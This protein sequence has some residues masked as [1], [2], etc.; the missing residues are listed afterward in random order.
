VILLWGLRHEAPMAY[1]LRAL[2]RCGA[3]T[4]MIDQRAYPTVTGSLAACQDGAA[5]WISVAGYRRPVEG[6]CG[7]F[8]RPYPVPPRYHHG[9]TL[10]QVA[11]IDQMMLTLA[12]TAPAHIAVVNRP[13][14]MAS[15]DSKPAQLAQLEDLGFLVPDTIV[16][17]D[18]EIAEDFWARHGTVVY[19]STSGIRSIASTLT[20]AHRD[21]LDRLAT[22]P[23]QFQEFIP[24]DDYRVHVVGDET[25][26]THIV[27]TATDYRYAAT[28]AAQRTMAAA[29]LPD[30]VA[31]QCR[32]ATRELGLLLAGIDLRRTPDGDWYCFEVNTAPAFSWFQDHTGQPIAD[33]VA[34]LLQ[35]GDRWAARTVQQDGTR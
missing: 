29:Q 12:E 10:H 20:T 17:N 33:A 15:N 4:V 1:V 18:R 13:S 6:F 30:H 9:L 32:Y 16:T 21:R 28:Q 35:H 2:T 31:D 19:K 11:A 22:C 26:A 14:A 5:G 23:T 25:F 7:Y 27:S 34:T 8:L 3:E 24:G